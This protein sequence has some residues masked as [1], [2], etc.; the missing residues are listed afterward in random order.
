MEQRE[1]KGPH[2][3][4]VVLL[5]STAID[6]DSK[7]N[8][9]WQSKLT[10][11]NANFTHVALCLGLG[12]YLHATPPNVDF[13]Y[14]EDLF[15]DYNEWRAIRHRRAVEIDHDDYTK[16]YGAAFFYLKM[17]YIDHKS[18]FLGDEPLENE[19]FCS[20]LI[21][22]IY[23]KVGIEILP[24]IG[25]PFPVHFETLVETEPQNWKDVTDEHKIGLD[26]LRQHPNQKVQTFQ[27]FD[28]QRRMQV[29]AKEAWEMHRL[30]QMMKKSFMKSDAEWGI[31]S[32]AYPDLAEPEFPFEYW[33]VS[34]KQL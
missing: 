21:R 7:K 31:S 23:R 32:S 2:S 14:A 18:D 3:G 1:F 29:M 6:K 27:F 25:K 10:G 4:D 30:G 17:S 12:K 20:L 15:S 22:N 24:N 28:M 34:K 11:L 19:T 33:D 13:V 16:I 9:F 26:I 8:K 5:N